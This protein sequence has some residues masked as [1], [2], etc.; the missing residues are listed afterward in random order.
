MEVKRDEEFDVNRKKASEDVE[1]AWDFLDDK[2][3]KLCLRDVTVNEAK[4]LTL[5][6]NSRRSLGK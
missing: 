3:R 1:A 4:I 5:S 2:V 6:A